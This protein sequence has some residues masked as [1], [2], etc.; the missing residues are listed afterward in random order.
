[1]TKDKDFKRLVRTRA[2][3][4]GRRYTE[5]R[6]E[7]RSSESPV[8]LCRLG[9]GA[10]DES[11]VQR[12]WRAV[13]DAALR[14]LYPGRRR[15]WSPAAIGALVDTVAPR[16]LLVF[17]DS[18]GSDLLVPELVTVLSG[19]PRP[20]IATFSRPTGAPARTASPSAG[21]VCA[22]YVRPSVSSSEGVPAFTIVQ[23]GALTEWLRDPAIKASE[24]KMRELVGL[25]VGSGEHHVDFG[26]SGDPVTVEIR[27]PNAAALIGPAGS[28]VADLQRALA[29]LA[30]RV[31]HVNI[32][33]EASR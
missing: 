4:E 8:L 16:A 9:L 14:P 23:L 22:G 2:R 19:D 5:T 7:L 21:D 11:F 6:A 13:S 26:N 25:V 12:V 18:E 30:E 10:D 20:P 3:A 32:V 29:V 33:E 28:T 17:L 27:T 24:A 15:Y 31:V 1:M